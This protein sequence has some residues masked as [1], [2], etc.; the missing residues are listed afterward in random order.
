MTRVRRRVEREFAVGQQRRGA[1]GAAPGQGADAGAQFVEVDRLDQIVVGAGIEAGNLVAGG[2]AGGQDQDRHGLAAP[3]RRVQHIHAGEARQAEIKH[4]QIESFALQRE[5]GG[6]AIAHPVDGKAGL[7]Q[8][9]GQAVA[10][11]GVVF[12]KQDAH[13]SILSA[14]YSQAAAATQTSSKTAASGRADGDGLFRQAMFEAGEHGAAPDFRHAA[15]CPKRRRRVDEDHDQHRRRQAFVQFFEPFP[16]DFVVHRP[17]GE[18][19]QD[20]EAEQQHDGPAAGR[21][22]A[23]VVRRFQLEQ[24]AQGSP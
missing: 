12:D 17:A 16:A 5:V 1:A 8:A 19:G 7:A 4:H 10:K 6:M 18:A 24:A 20:A 3:A 21:I 14:G 23:G 22:V 13:G 9:D 15:G 11:L 2:V